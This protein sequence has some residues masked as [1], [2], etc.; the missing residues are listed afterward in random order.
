M[1]SFMWEV[2][3]NLML[4]HWTVHIPFFNYYVH[5][6]QDEHIL[7]FVWLSSMDII[8]TWIL[9][10][11]FPFLNVCNTWTGI[12]SAGFLTS[13]N[14]YLSLGFQLCHAPTIM[15]YNKLQS[16]HSWLALGFFSPQQ[17]DGTEPAVK[18][19]LTHAETE[20]HRPAR[21]TQPLEHWLDS[22]NEVRCNCTA[23]R[24]MKY[25]GCK[26]VRMPSAAR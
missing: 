13:W 4:N 10:I 23:W 1:Q 17:H 11:H 7:M 5:G 15:L 26:A 22:S 18:V 8:H 16:L 24:L 12:I 25:V 20:D 2:K 6:C 19:G 9:S 3:Q 14:R 21:S